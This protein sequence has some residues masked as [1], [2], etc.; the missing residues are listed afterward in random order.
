[1]N[2]EEYKKL[3]VGDILVSI[4]DFPFYKT[5]VKVIVTK[6][7]IWYEDPIIEELGKEELQ[8]QKC[9]PPDYMCYYK[10][11]GTNLMSLSYEIP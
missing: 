6:T 4:S 8:R 11:I 7:N 1:M 10:K 2:P 9:I 5:G 3:K